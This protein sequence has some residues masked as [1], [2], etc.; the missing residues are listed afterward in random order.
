MVHYCKLCARLSGPFHLYGLHFRCCSKMLWLSQICSILSA[1]K[2]GQ[3]SSV[4]AKPDY[5]ISGRPTVA[6]GSPELK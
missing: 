2:S 3:D 5:Q 4:A 1:Q 6:V